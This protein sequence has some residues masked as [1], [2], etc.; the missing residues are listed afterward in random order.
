MAGVSMTLLN[1]ISNIFVSLVPGNSLSIVLSGQ[2]ILNVI[3]AGCDVNLLANSFARY[4]SFSKEYKP[5]PSDPGSL[6]S[7][8]WLTL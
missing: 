2:S 1:Q 7:K 8:A 6:E 5:Y 3:T 4:A